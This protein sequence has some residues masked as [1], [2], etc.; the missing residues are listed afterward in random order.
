MRNKIIIRFCGLAVAVLAAVWLW[1]SVRPMRKGFDPK[2][3]ALPTDAR[4][5]LETGERF[6]LLSLDNLPMMGGTSASP[7]RELFNGYGV[8][9]RAEIRNA[10]ERTELLRALYKG[11]AGSDGSVNSCFHPRHG[12]SATLGGEAVDLVICFECLQIQTFTNHGEGVLAPSAPVLTTRSPQRTF[13]RA[14]KRARLPV[15]KD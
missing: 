11:I 1:P 7:P 3:N 9:G 13:N 10:E 12:I 8:L 5:V 14:L 4:K 2:Q 15:A 6:I